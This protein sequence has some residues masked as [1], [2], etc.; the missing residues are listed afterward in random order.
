MNRPPL[1]ALLALAAAL[2]GCGDKN[3]AEPP[4]ADVKPA[5]AKSAAAPADPF[6]V[7]PDAETATW[8]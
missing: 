1:L 3:K 2:G 5:P 8:L 6:V 7:K 4:K